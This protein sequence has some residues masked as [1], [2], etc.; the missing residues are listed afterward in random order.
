MVAHFVPRPG[1]DL[2]SAGLVA[3]FLAGQI[4]I[5]LFRLQAPRPARFG[6]QMYASVRFQ[7]RFA[8]ISTA[9]IVTEIRSA[10][11]LGN[12]RADIDLPADRIVAH[13][14]AATP[15]I[16]AVRVEFEGAA[17]DWPC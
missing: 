11:F 4:A 3:A 2:L 5:P 8:T 15:G 1:R 12:P 10:D 17:R 13:L 9:G 14:C 7:P 6:W 16:R